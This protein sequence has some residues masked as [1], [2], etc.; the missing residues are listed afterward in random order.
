MTQEYQ[1]YQEEYERLIRIDGWV[2]LSIL[3]I[4]MQYPSFRQALRWKFSQ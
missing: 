1:E 3:H 4:Q 2:Q